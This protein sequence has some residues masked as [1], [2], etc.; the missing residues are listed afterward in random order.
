MNILLIALSI[1]QMGYSELNGQVFDIDAI[2]GITSF[3][4]VRE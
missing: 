3:I 2:N 4:W 1:L